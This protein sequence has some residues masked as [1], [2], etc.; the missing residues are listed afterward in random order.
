MDAA[1]E[2]REGREGMVERGG[3]DERGRDREGWRGRE[4]GGGGKV[5]RG[6]RG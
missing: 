1:A 5:E 6:V 3:R 4:G 2:E